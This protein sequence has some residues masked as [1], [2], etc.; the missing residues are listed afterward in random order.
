M[1]RY[2]VNRVDF[3]ADAPE[4]ADLGAPLLERLMAERADSPRP[5]VFFDT[6]TT[7][8]LD[9]PRST[10]VEIGAIRIE[11]DGRVSTLETLINPETP[12][13]A[14]ASNVHGIHD[15]DVADAPTFEEVHADLL[16]FFDQAVVAGFNSE[17]YDVPMLR[18]VC[19][20]RE[21]E[22]IVTDDNPRLDV[23][24]VWGAVSG[25]RHGKLTNLAEIY[26]VGRES[27]HRALED[28]RMTIDVLEGMLADYGRVS[29]GRAIW[30]EP[31][32]WKTSSRLHL[33][34]PERLNV[35]RGEPAQPT[36]GPRNLVTGQASTLA[37]V[38]K[39]IKEHLEARP[40]LPTAQYPDIAAQVPKATVSTVTYALSEMLGAGEVRPEQVACPIQQDILKRF[41]GSA[42][43]ICGEDKAGYL[44]PMR[45]AYEST[46]ALDELKKQGVDEVCYVQLRIAKMARE[47]QDEVG[48]VK[49][50]SED[51]ESGLID[52]P[53]STRR[54]KSLLSMRR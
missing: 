24:R 53:D 15:R 29:I 10:I 18:K 28:V 23:R 34:A 27:A 39:A 41:H 3:P 19:R 48:S 17:G 51:R 46:E 5:V 40:H 32:S 7:G 38:R 44:K 25:T 13:P 30:P 45:E 9:N 47:S 8:L 21:L 36:A 22:E 52:N 14:E 12:I 42:V 33:T 26:E 35:L 20:Q 37:R 54:P 1:A 31:E 4:A 11:P 2:S 49:T 43:A 16:A 50:E 6:E